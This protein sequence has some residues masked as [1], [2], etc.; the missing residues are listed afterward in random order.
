MILLCNFSDKHKDKTKEELIKEL[1]D[2]Y[3]EK[4]K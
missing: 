2:V 1:Y 3:V 4:K